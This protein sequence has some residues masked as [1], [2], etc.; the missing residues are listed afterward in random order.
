[1]SNRSLSLI[2]DHNVVGK[3]PPAEVDGIIEE[4]TMCDMAEILIKYHI[5]PGV[6]KNYYKTKANLLT[7]DWLCYDFDSGVGSF[8]IKQILSGEN[9][10]GNRFNFIIA[11][12]MNHLKDKG[13]GNGIRERFHVFIPLN[14]P[15]TDADVYRH[16]WLTF[17]K[18]YFNKISIDEGVK[19]ASRFF[20]KHSSILFLEEKA[21]DLDIEPF[22]CSYEIKELRPSLE[23]QKS[24]DKKAKR[25]R[26][27]YG[28]RVKDITTDKIELTAWFKDVVDGFSDVGDRYHTM[29]RLVG[30]MKSNGVGRHDAV[31]L[32]TKHAP[33]VEGRDWEKLAE[34][35][36][37]WCK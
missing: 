16:T 15:I 19:D 25:I 17:R 9:V 5:A 10:S 30:F 18:M 1:M 14:H 37:D 28:E 4:V 35:F 7:I 13:D 20:A 29:Q 31:S 32:I 23:R 34:K 12:S 11:G 21:Q 24:I 6:F 27:K 36:Y 8:D 26:K 3:I 33:H 22:K 2:Y